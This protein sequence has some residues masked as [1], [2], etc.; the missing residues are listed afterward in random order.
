MTLFWVDYLLKLVEGLIAV[1]TL[2]GQQVLIVVPVHDVQEHSQGVD[3]FL[4]GISAPTPVVVYVKVP[5]IH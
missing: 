5:P 2:T 3:C 1:L 4:Q